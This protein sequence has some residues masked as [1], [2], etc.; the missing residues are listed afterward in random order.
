MFS[1][2]SANS[3]LLLSHGSNLLLP[4]IPARFGR[5]SEVMH[6]DHAAQLAFENTITD[7]LFSVAHRFQHTRTEL[8]F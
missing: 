7:Y 8:E 5:V 4:A 6:A 3:L 2:C 1:Y